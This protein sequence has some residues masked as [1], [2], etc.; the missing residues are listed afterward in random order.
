MSSVI[1]VAWAMTPRQREVVLGE[2]AVINRLTLL[3]INVWCWKRE[4]KDVKACPGL[5]GDYLS[6]VYYDVSITGS[7]SFSPVKETSLGEAKKKGSY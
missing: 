3:G 5:L 2:R 7:P 1:G 4:M 6:G